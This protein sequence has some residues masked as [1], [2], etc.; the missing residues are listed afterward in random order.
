MNVPLILG[1]SLI[2]YLLFL[3]FVIRKYKIYR[4]PI[5]KIIV[6]SV[7][8]IAIGFLVSELRVMYTPH[9]FILL[10]LFAGNLIYYIVKLVKESR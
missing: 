1:G 3:F 6:I 7:S 2:V 9:L 5:T 4:S 10:L 8:G